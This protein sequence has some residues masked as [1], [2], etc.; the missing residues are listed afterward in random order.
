M[1]SGGE[2]HR[3]DGQFVADAFL[4]LYGRKKI[5]ASVMLRGAEGFGL[6]HHLRTH[7]LLTLSEDLPLVSV[8]VDTRAAIEALLGEVVSIKRHGLITLERARMLSGEISPIALPDELHEATKL[9]IYL[10]RQERADG[11]SPS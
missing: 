9:T 5:A 10:G 1:P 6:K 4:D 2:R 11:P 7:R 3:T 8:A